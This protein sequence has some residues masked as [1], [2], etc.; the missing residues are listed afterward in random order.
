MKWRSLEESQHQAEGRTL[1]EIY[2]ERKALIERYVPVEVRETH[3]R[4]IEEL[5]QSGIQGRVI[6][7]GSSAPEFAL[8]DQ[9]GKIVRSAELLERGLVVICFVRGRW[10]PFCVGQMQAM[11]AIVPELQGLNASFVAISPQTVHQSFL[12][13]D[14]HR[15]R[16]PLLSDSGNAVARKFG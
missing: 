9:N 12:M 3:L 7:S 6:P 13:C 11:N 4:A 5:K 2:T 1:R 14:Q 15:L 16:F 10:C 8:Q